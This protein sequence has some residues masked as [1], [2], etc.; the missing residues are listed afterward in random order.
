MNENLDIPLEGALQ[1]LERRIAPY[2]LVKSEALN[3][4]L[5]VP[6]LDEFFGQVVELKKKALN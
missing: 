2:G 1:E 3:W 4:I 5:T 6:G